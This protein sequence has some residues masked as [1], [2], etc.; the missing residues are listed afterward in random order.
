MDKLKYGAYQ[1]VNNCTKIKCCEK[2]IIITDNVTKFIAE[3]IYEESELVTPGNTKVFI[4]ENYGNRPDDGSNPLTFP[5]E[6]G[7]EMKDADVSF[8]C[9]DAKKG[10]LD[11]FRKP[12]CEYV[13]N[14]PNLRHAHMPGISKLLME[15]GMNVDYSKVQEL[16]AKIDKIVF[17]AEKIRVTTPAG[18]DF[19]AYFNN[20]WKW[21]ISDGNIRA[22]NWSNL[23]DGEIFTCV[24]NIPEGKI[25]VDGVIGDYLCSK[26]GLLKNN[27]ITLKIKDSRITSIECCNPELL[28]EFTAYTNQ[29]KNA[30]RVGEFA[31]GT[32]IGLSNL[33]GNLLQDEKFPGIHVAFGH[34]Y[35]EMTGSDWGSK[36]H[37]DC[38]LCECTITV[39]DKVIMKNG[40][41]LI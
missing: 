13:E 36:A 3:K 40:K 14:N 22:D 17:N 11:T 31:I 15:T 37:I 25:V 8:Y 19:T 5:K 9:A 23:P 41:F 29:D 1:A 24:K 6:I 10:E 18:T 33:V 7:N 20:D 21:I 35:P 16:T 28:E 34:G 38:F 39:G 26:Y 27:P 2:V 4:M 30:N 32:N 12:M